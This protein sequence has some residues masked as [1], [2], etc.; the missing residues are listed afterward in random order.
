MIRKAVLLL[1]ISCAFNFKAALS[2]VTSYVFV[3]SQGTY[4]SISGGTPAILTGNGTDPVQDEGYVNNIPIGFSFNYL[5]VNYNSISA[6]T[7][8]FASF[9][10]LTS[11]F[12]SNNLSSGTAARPLLAPLWED[13]ALT[14]TTGL[15]Y[16]TTGGS[17]NR[18][19]ILQWSNVLYDFGAGAASISFQLRLYEMTNKIEFI[20]SQLS[21]AV[22]DF[23][24][25]ASIGITSAA[26]GSGSFLSLKSSNAS[27]QVSADTATNT[28]VAK[29]ASGQVYSF[30]PPVCIAPG[31][32]KATGI[33]STG[34]VVSWIDGSATSFEYAVNTNAVPPAS[35]TTTSLTS[36][37]AGGLMP[38]TKYYLHVRKDCSGNLSGWASYVFATLCEASGV[39]YAMPIS[40]ATPPAL[41][42]CT[43]SMDDNQDGNTWRTYPS[44]GTGWTDN[45]V[46]YVY[47]YNTMT[48]ANDWLFTTGLNLVG[49]TSYR[50]K[51]KYNNDANSLYTEKLKVAYGINPVAAS[52]TNMLA[53]YTS[54]YSPVA[55]MV[56][57]DFTP[58][59]SGIY[60]LG[61]QAYSDAD[62]DVLIL[63]DISINATPSCD[64]P[65]NL[66]ADVQ[67]TGTSVNVSWQLPLSGT[68]A[69]Y[70]YAVI[71][72]DA[73]PASGA[74]TTALSASVS[75][76]L[77]FTKY[78]LHIRSV[79]GSSFSEWITKEFATIGNDEPCHAIS[80]TAN[81][82]PVCGDT[83]LATSPNDPPTA[84]SNPN[85]SVWYKYTAVANGTVVLKMTTPA[86]P[87][88][89]LFGWV[90]WYDH[91][92]D[93]P[94]ISLYQ[95]DVC[96]Q[97][98]SRGNNDTT[99]ILSPVLIA[100]NTYYIM[101]DGFSDDA[102][103]FCISIPSCSPAINVKMDDIIS[104][105]AKATWS[106]TGSFILEYGPHGFTPG[107]GI[108]AGNGGTMVYPAV[109][110]QLIPGLTL[111][112]SYDVYVRQNCSSAGNGCSINSPVTAFT[113]LGP[114]PANDE[115]TGAIGLNVFD[116]VCGGATAGSTL[117]AT[118][119]YQAP[120]PQCNFTNTGYD[121]DVWFSFTP[122]AGQQFV[123]IIF[124][125]TG[126]NTNLISQVYRSSDNTCSGTLI[127]YQC[128]DDEGVGN[129]PTFLSMPV[130]AGTTYFIR[131]YT[132]GRGVNGQFT[133]CITKG[134]LVND[135]ASG[136]LGL[137]VDAPCTGASFT[138]VGATHNTGEPT[139][140]C[141]STR[142]Y[143]SV[144][145]TFVAPAG[146]A[147]RISTALGSGN[148]LSNTRVALF[149][150]GN[151]NNYQSFQIIACDEDGGS[152]SFGNMSVLYA[153]GLNEGWT[154]YIEVDKYDSLT[155]SGT[156]CI[157]VEKLTP[158]MLSVNNNC[159]SA[160]QVPVGSVPTYTGWVPLMDAESKLI[161]LVVN[162][163]GGAAD[164]YSVVQNVKAGAVRK[165]IVSG[166]YYLNR[167]YKITNTTTG[168][169]SISVQLFY[170][171]S[172][173]AALKA[174]DSAASVN[175]LRI[176][177]Q[178]GTDCQA[179]FIGANGTNT[180][181]LQTA[182]GSQNGVSWIRFNTIG[183]S[184]FYLHST[185]SRFMAKIF[186]QGAYSSGL[187]RHNEVTPAW[188]NILNT[189]ARSQPYN[190][191]AFGN[192]GGAE[193]VPPGFSFTSTSDTT[194]IVDWVLLEIKNSGGALISRRAAFVREDGLI[195]D[196]DGV[197][198]VSMYGQGFGF[199]NIFIRH[200]NHLG[201]R[202]SV[203][204]LF[205][206]IALGNNLPSLALYDFTT[207]QNKAYQNVAIT[208]NPA[209]AQ[210]N[211]A[212]MMWAGDVNKDEYVRVISQ[213]FPFIS[214]DISYVLSNILNGN[215]NGS[216]SGYSIGD[217]NMDG[218]VRVISQ[219]F[220]FIT[221]EGSYLL[222]TILGGAMTRTLREHK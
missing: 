188:A 122:V 98:G 29:P 210:S 192:Y 214:S 131:V 66:I 151:V 101:I 96:R 67:S 170:L 55:K 132:Q 16:L 64:V 83:R 94:N 154:Y 153:T 69:G 72:S 7:N 111:T 169:A 89:P 22:Q 92:S 145:Y 163:N 164:A 194:D 160:Y 6:S 105:S 216:V 80:I 162:P 77:P 68:P 2:Q 181:L 87:A 5:G 31:N 143:A 203:Q 88:D 174:L 156:F 180:E 54:V 33:T 135:N 27:P 198:P 176:T 129:M 211:T 18:I 43:T 200:R 50:L 100:G 202:T 134:L 48:P 126:G 44:A 137:T 178:T 82:I 34:A 133:I 213:A 141:S 21:S 155:S 138:N 152:G 191:P 166:E 36:A 209:M 28:I 71:T 147:V 136:A 115:C 118:G 1:M 116:S 218:Y 46:A 205:T 142:G 58:A 59:T 112:T 8:G 38:G 199:Y 167:N 212:F 10:T 70:E 219:A 37:F 51:F 125:Y 183:F 11:A 190:T 90:T 158:A 207:S 78:Y 53:D 42:L 182:N 32:L 109:S 222:G 113:T 93:C 13:L 148:T 221:S 35:G 103:E 23:S 130:T 49:G 146:G 195:V 39:P 47:N 124:T 17:G 97:F 172:E 157:T 56:S 102:G 140:S 91:N 62:K 95:I 128:S 45:V 186:L 159:N 114:P 19:F 75:G 168:N 150:G 26:T 84:C 73:P 20:Y 127:P 52:M 175:Y 85:N 206:S 108:A 63:D 60:Y 3:A 119:S 14:I 215:L 120:L 41:P 65:T 9:S 193:S 57:L 99:Y 173:L 204:Q 30:A 74:A 187:N 220:P 161:A 149:T 4:T 179:D 139:G 184:N 40:S 76:L 185:R 171:D 201:V 86:A 217:I 117:D 110:P 12:F 79:C 165:D 107:T 144:W 196:L 177:R 121:D 123:N 24:G 25:G 81:G 104:T 189:Y 197:S 15:Q 208:S 106:G 61:F